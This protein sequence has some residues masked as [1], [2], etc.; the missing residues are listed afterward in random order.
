MEGNPSE[1]PFKVVGPNC[2]EL[3]FICEV[4][5]TKVGPNDNYIL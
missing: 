5:K 3:E 4:Q 1:H 2:N